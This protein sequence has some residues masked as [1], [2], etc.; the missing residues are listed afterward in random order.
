MRPKSIDTSEPETYTQQLYYAFMI[1]SLCNNSAIKKDE[2]TGEWTGFDADM[3][4][5]TE[6]NLFFNVKK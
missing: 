5:L 2:E 4:K 6:R 1:A 3:A